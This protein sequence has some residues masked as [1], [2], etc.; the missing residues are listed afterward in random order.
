M[1]ALN[2]TVERPDT[3]DVRDL[4]LRHFQ[5]MRSQ[6]PE[7][8]CHVMAP[9]ALSDADALLFGLRRDGVLLGIGAITVIGTDHGELKSMHTAEEARGQGVGRRLINGLTD[10]AEARGIKRLSL[11]TG[12]GATFAAARQLYLSEGFSICPPF[13]SYTADPLSVFMTKLL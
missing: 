7:E 5:L 10:A 6:S 8:S 12:T 2:P 11:E 9:D 3:A 1:D 4:L 13:G